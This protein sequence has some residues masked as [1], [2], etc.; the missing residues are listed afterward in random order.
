MS[1]A[2]HEWEEVNC[3]LLSGKPGKTKAFSL[4]QGSELK[5]DAYCIQK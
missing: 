3:D 5:R 4:E 2:F 1:E